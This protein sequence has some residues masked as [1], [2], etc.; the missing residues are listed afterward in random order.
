LAPRSAVMN[1]RAT[2]ILGDAHV[3]A[4]SAACVEDTI[5]EAI[6]E[7][8]VELEEEEEEDGKAVAVG[9][10]ISMGQGSRHMSQAAELIRLALQDGG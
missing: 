7:E 5:P 10:H 6:R 4:A 8:D 9:S 3:A 1:K 2:N